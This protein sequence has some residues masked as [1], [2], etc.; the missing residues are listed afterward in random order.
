MAYSYSPLTVKLTPQGNLKKL[1][2]LRLSFDISTQY[3]SV[4]TKNGGQNYLN[5]NKKNNV[6]MIFTFHDKN[7]INL[8]L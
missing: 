3:S 1:K 4:C 2:N 6:H 5:K 8:V 7:N